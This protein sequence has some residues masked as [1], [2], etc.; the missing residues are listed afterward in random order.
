MKNL[1]KCAVLVS[2]LIAVLAA[3][4]PSLFAPVLAQGWGWGDRGPRWEEPQRSQERPYRGRRTERHPR[5]RQLEDQ[6]AGGWTSGNAAQ[7]EL[8][9]LDA[10]IEKVSREHRRA[11]A[12]AERAD[13]YD[14]MFIFGRSLRQSRRCIEMDERV[15][16]TR[17]R[18][19]QLRAERKAMSRSTDRRT[20]QADILAEL[21]R[22]DCG[23][24]YEREYQARH[25]APSFFDLWSDED[26]DDQ[27]GSGYPSQAVP[28]ESYRTVCVRLCDGF[29]YPVSYSTLPSRFPEDEQKCKSQC[30]APSELFFHR[31]QDQDVNQA[32][33][34]NGTPYT[35]LPNAFRHT[36]VYIRGCSCNASE[37]SREEIA[38]SEEALRQKTAAAA[39]AASPPKP[40]GG[41]P[42]NGAQPGAAG[43]AVEGQVPAAPAGAQGQ[44]GAAGTDAGA[45]TSNT[46]PGAAA[47][48]AGKTAEPQPQAR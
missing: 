36:K 22:Y 5:C 29:Y 38:K 46:D 45:A 27:Q 31:V 33:S 19:E 25:R 16:A 26:S 42:A 28:Y 47:S 8:P 10:E 20:R 39:A 35:A 17:S 23:E 13:C 15:E 7:E 11:Q 12:E 6:L 37:Y 4:F 18:L 43:G 41:A 3:A 30:A 14:D 24:S 21:A 9:K 34:Q 32:V 48:A 1:L 40:D 2:P 44:S